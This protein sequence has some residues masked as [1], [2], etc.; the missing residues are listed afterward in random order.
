MKNQFT[1][2]IILAN[3]VRPGG[4]CIAGINPNTGTWIRPISHTNHEAIPSYA[5]TN[6]QLLDKALIPLTGIKPQ[7]VDKYQIENEY[8]NQYTWAIKGKANIKQIQR[9]CED[10]GLF[11]HSISDTVEPPYLDGLPSKEWKS[12]QLV[13]VDTIFSK[14]FYSGWRT[15]FHDGNGNYMYLKVTDPI[16][17]HSLDSGNN[18]DGQCILTIS[19][20][21]PWAPKNVNTSPLCYK[22]VAGVIK[23]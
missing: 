22:L 7:P 18:L 6:L 8:V 21:K 4:R 23:L 9:Y 13:M 1:E 5:V 16:A 12:L 2:I 20:G 14:D 17:I 10:K 11:L 19:L 15:E 3:S